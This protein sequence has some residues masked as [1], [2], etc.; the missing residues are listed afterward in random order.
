MSAA[1]TLKLPESPYASVFR[2]IE[3]TLRN[4]PTLKTA[5]QP[6]SWRTWEGKPADKQAVPLT[7]APGIRLTPDPGADQ[8]WSPDAAVGTLTIHCELFVRGLCIDDVLNLW[9]AVVRALYPVDQT[10]K[11]AIQAALVAAGAETGLVTFVKPA[12]D[13]SAEAGHSTASKP[14]PH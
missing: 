9:W 6:T 13:V 1:T 10:T 8:W 11:L 3:K 4:D 7:G 12:A 2:A 14:W 5:V